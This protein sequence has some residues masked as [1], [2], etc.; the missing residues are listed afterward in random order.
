VCLKEGTLWFKSWS[1]I[2]IILLCRDSIYKYE[3]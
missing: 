2:T 3:F 1:D